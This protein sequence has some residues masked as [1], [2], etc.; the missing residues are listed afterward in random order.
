MFSGIVQ[1]IGV[2]KTI[3]QQN[4][5]LRLTIASSLAPQ[6]SK[7]ASVSVAG[8]C[9]TIVATNAQTFTV[10]VI[11]ETTR[12][13]TLGRLQEGSRVNLEPELKL[14][15][16]LGGSLVTGHIDAVGTVES[17]VSAQN[18]RVLSLHVPPELLPLLARKGSVTLDGVNLT[19]VDV[20]DAHALLSVA[21]I[22]YTLEQ[23]TLGSVQSG[24][25][26]NLEVDLIARYVQRQLQ[27][28]SSP[29]TL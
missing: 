16:G 22:P 23:T 18:D 2:I 25:H 8:A 14:S 21:L 6:L 4:H 26:I 19:I 13:T 11:P 28:T 12:L 17:F 20:D 5:L 1:N 24:D 27:K 29:N 7:R 9:L 10:E 3:E 15:D